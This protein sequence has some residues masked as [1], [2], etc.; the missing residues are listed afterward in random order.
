MAVVLGFAFLAGC[1]SPPQRAAA[2]SR[3]ASCKDLAT[4]IIAGNADAVA[5]HRYA[6]A[7]KTAER[8]ARVSLACS[9]GGKTPA[10]TFGDRWR[11]ANALV[12]AA[13]LAHEANE[14]PR[15]HALLR[16]GFAIMHE[17]RPPHHVSQITST[18]ISETLDGARHDL[19]GQWAYW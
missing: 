18:L 12:V 16:E 17:L 4:Q 3:P 7:S 5:A 15:A 1:A 9:T 2:P 10:Q 8:A 11:G 6:Q 13:E 19:A 14:L